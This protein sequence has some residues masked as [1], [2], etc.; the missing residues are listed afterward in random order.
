[1]VE[2]LTPNQTVAGSIPAKV[3]Q[4]EPGFPHFFYAMRKRKEV[5][6]MSEW[7]IAILAIVAFAGFVYFMKSRK[8][9]KK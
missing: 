5:N 7:P 8:K 9:S 6:D 3:P 1:M 2:H 4:P